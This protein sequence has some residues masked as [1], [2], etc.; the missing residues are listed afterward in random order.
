MLW[1]AKTP[2]SSGSYVD[3]IT[4]ST[5][6]IE[7]EDIDNNSYRSVINGNLIRSRLASKL[8][9]GSLS[10]N[11]VTNSDLENLMTVINQNPL[12]VKVKSPIFG[13]NGWVELECY[14]SKAKVE[15]LRNDPTSGSNTN[16]QWGNL[17]FNIIQ[18]KVVSGQ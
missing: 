14:V 8:Y 6:S 13:T 5:Y 11:Y 7:W 4:P 1:Q 17:S 9:K 10:F 2:T 16:N 12:Y 18:A 3:M 15:M